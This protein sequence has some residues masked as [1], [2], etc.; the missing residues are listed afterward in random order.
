MEIEIQ[1]SGD[2]VERTELLNGTV[3]IAIEGASPDGAWTVSG[4]VSWNRGLVD[5]AGEG[6]ISLSRD[7]DELFASLTSATID[8]SA[9]EEGDVHLRV[10]YEIDGGAG[11]FDA[12]SG[13]IAGEI[14]VTGEVFE[15]AWQAAVD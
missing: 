12:A 5:Y 11:R 14:R 8:Q 3:T 9:A 13:S 1:A 15:G 6:D 10:R 4:V 2:V 7:E